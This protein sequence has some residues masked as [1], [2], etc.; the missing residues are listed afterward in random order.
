MK[1][2]AASERTLAAIRAAA[3]GGDIA[4]QYVLGECFYEGMKGAPQD[5]AQALVWWRRSAAGNM[6]NAQGFLGL[7]HESGE[8]GLAVDLAEGAR[9]YALAAAQGLD[10]ALF[11]LGTCYYFGNGVPRDLVE[12]ARLY[13]LSA[14]QGNDLAQANLSNAYIKGE[15]VAVDHAEA[16]RWARLSADKGNAF[17]ELNV[18]VLYANGLG[19]PPDLRAATMWISR[20]ATKDFEQAKKALLKLAADG[21]PEAVAAVQRLRLAP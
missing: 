3:E 12:A 1:K 2:W 16:M 8:G 4:A 6:A 17:G 14:E 13:R 10:S 9:L 19:V 18:G 5:H 15:G 11:N 7:M 21:V 20:A